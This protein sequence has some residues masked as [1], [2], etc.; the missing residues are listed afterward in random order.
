MKV[1]TTRFGKIEVKEE[2]I[3]EFV[4]GPY[5]FEDQTEFVLWAEEESPFFWL[6]SINDP[7]LSFVVSEP[8]PF[9]EDY[10]FDIGDQLKNQLKIINQEDVLVVNIV[11]VP[12]DPQNMTMNLKSPIIINKNQKIA[13]QIILETE[14]YPVRYQLFNNSEHDNA[15]A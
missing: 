15:S 1:E 14:D 11:V 13:K 6:Q 4:V 10:E 7:D 12:T 2:E 3:I 9:Y 8:W 5:G